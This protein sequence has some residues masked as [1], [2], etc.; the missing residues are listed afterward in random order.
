M[1]EMNPPFDTVSA[2]DNVGSVNL[3][4]MPKNSAGRI[5]QSGLASRRDD[6]RIAR[7]FNAGSA[8]SADKSRRDG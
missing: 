4:G 8:V 7:R 6:L 5:A 2:L 3:P 1:T